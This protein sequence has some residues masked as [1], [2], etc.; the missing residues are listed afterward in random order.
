M[1]GVAS[2]QRRC[3]WWR[4]ARTWRPGTP[5]AAPRWA[6][7]PARG[8][9]ACGRALVHMCDGPRAK[10]DTRTAVLFVCLGS[11]GLFFPSLSGGGIFQRFGL[12]RASA[13]NLLYLLVQYNNVIILICHSCV[14]FVFH[15]FNNIHT[16]ARNSVTPDCLAAP[17]PGLPIHHLPEPRPAH[18]SV[19]HGPAPCTAS[20]R[21]AP[22]STPRT[23]RAAPP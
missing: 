21:P 13:L 19:A 7:P 12:R 22:P 3:C 16:H 10:G 6:G 9:S 8:S 14:F 23:R 2:R 4:P 15:N 18:H 20:W 17:P 1:W 11:L 5:R